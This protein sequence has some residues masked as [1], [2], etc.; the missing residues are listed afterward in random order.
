[1]S[2]QPSALNPIALGR[3]TRSGASAPILRGTCALASE[4]VIQQHQRPEVRRRPTRFFTDVPQAET[5]RVSDSTAGGVVRGVRAGDFRVPTT[6]PRLAQLRCVRF[7]LAGACA[8]LT[9][10]AAGCAQSSKKRSGA[11]SCSAVWSQPRT[12][13]TQDGH[14]VYVE[15]PVATR[16]GS[17]LAFLG[18]P[19]II[20]SVGGNRPPRIRDASQIPPVVAGV[21]VDSSGYAHAV[22]AP[23]SLSTMLWP[24]SFARPD[25]AIDVLWGV[26]DSPARGT[27]SAVRS[28][29]FGR[30]DGRRW[31]LATDAISTDWLRWEYGVADA[32]ATPAGLLLA[33]PSTDRAIGRSGILF[34][35][36]TSAGW[37]NTLVATGPLP[38]G[39]ATLGAAK[40]T[41]VIGF[42]GSV[43]EAPGALANGVFVV[44]STNAGD[45]WSTPLRV[46]LFPTGSDGH[47]V[48]LV[49]AGSETPLHLFWTER[50]GP[51]FGSMIHHAI[52]H[53]GGAS[54]HTG[55]SLHLPVTT[56][57]L[58]AVA[59]G[60]H[61]ALIVTRDPEGG[62]VYVASWTST[63]S[64][65]ST[66]I[67]DRVLSVPTV[68][69]DGA[70]TVMLTWGVGRNED[71]LRGDRT[72]LPSLRYAT[73]ATHCH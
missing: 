32:A 17:S 65:V 57:V 34:A 26:P 7:V 52:S 35:K 62:R 25:G 19:T 30:F 8:F 72:T 4:T 51:R 61:E 18:T 45:T 47:V 39:Y 42:I 44:R 1:M 49:M 38:P 21:I 23:D 59:V 68:S 73:R 22:A 70:N 50:S 14:Y 28:L 60:T 69:V 2:P 37:K 31:S 56:D 64:A 15:T 11:D 53:D 66:P 55:A 33:A 41:F 9:P 63:W 46:S 12:L 40:S 5:M 71:V 16:L 36:M 67:P 3:P 48:K 43:Y 6:W 20:W 29:R 54:W 24:R 13:V 10:L 27:G 58:D